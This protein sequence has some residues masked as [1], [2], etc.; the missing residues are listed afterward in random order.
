MPKKVFI[1]GSN[2]GIG[3]QIAREMGKNGWS[4]LIGARDEDRGLEAVRELMGEGIEA[5]YL[6]IDLKNQKTISAAADIIK[7]QHTGIAMLINNAAIPGDMRKPGY[8][9]TADE[10]RVVMETNFFGPFE[11][12]RQLLST[13]EANNGRIINITI[14]IGA[15]DF[16]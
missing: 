8:E 6:N 13:L 14:P 5:G 11:L 9:F 2:K 10:L 1:T 7:S 4:V 16:F 3:K 12:T 15:T